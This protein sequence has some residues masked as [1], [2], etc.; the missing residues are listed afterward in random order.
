MVILLCL[1]VKDAIV[2]QAF[3][4]AQ[5]Q[6]AAPVAANTEVISALAR[7]NISV[8][9]AHRMAVYIENTGGHEREE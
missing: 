3:V 9:N 1:D 2:L 5:I 6:E 4:A 7:I 8:R